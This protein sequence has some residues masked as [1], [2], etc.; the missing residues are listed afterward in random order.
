MSWII[1]HQGRFITILLREEETVMTV[2][3]DRASFCDHLPLRSQQYIRQIRQELKDYFKEDPAFQSA[4][5]PHPCASGA[6]RLVGRMTET[7]FKAGVGPMAAVAGAIA[8]S[9][10]H[11]LLDAFCP[12]EMIIENGGDIFVKTEAPLTVGI[13]AGASSL[14]CQL[15]I[16]VPAFEDLAIC[17]SSG[18]VGHALSF[19]CSD[20]MVIVSRDAPLADAVATACGNLIH[21]QED[22]SEVVVKGMAIK[23]VRGAVAIMGERMA[24]LGDIKLKG[25]R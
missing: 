5:F 3:V 24:A 7:A 23:G 13:F 12:R 18:T 2:S 20:A 10:A 1:D 4:L 15:G 19:G 21:R 22:L 9:L 17:T 25:L 16:E 8:E 11:F 6:P 14:S